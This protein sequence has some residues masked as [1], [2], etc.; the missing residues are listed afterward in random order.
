M[1]QTSTNTRFLSTRYAETGTRFL[2]Y[3]QRKM[4][5]SRDDP[6]TV[7]INARPGTIRA[8]PQDEGIYVVDAEDKIPYYLSGWPPYT[9]PTRPPA[10]PDPI[11][12]FDHI[13]PP[14]DEFSAAT[15][16]A[17]IRLV[18]TIWEHYLGRKVRWYFRDAYPRLEV[19]PRVNLE[20]DS[21]SFFGYIE[22]GFE[23][24]E[25]R[26]GPFCQNF[27]VVA[28]EVGHIVLK[29]V[30][31]YPPY[32]TMALR[33]HEEACADL[34]ALVAVLHF[35]SVVDEVL[36]ETNGHLFSLNVLSRF[37]ELRKSK[38]LRDA[39]NSAT[40]SDVRWDSD[41]EH[42]KYQLALPFMGAAYDILVYIYQRHLV[43]RRVIPKRL[44][45]DSFNFPGESMPDIQ[46]EFGKYFT[47]KAEAFK[48]ALLNAR[49]DFAQL[50]V[51]TWK[52]TSMQDLEYPR[53]VQNMLD[54]ELELY[55]GRYR[56]IILDAFELRD[57]VP[58]SWE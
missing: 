46:G 7:Y 51:Q 14:D 36:E 32:R 48:E 18:L 45:D 19:I 33:A 37:G 6:E 26:S 28:H 12:H 35:E 23:N 22:C 55:R 10:E 40:L 16:F 25:E 57:I 4:R 58:P 1:P 31:G 29:D 17:A 47:R 21:A 44:A 8:G 9:G 50:L 2:I 34:A 53:V 56:S 15:V 27:D 43:Q 20:R 5:K 54:A 41:Q 24:L 52:K 30:I 49:D 3:P 11:G 38:E 42:Y 39:F 13:E